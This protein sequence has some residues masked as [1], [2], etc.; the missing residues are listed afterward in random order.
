MTAS[1][2]LASW[3]WPELALLA[4]MVLVCAGA[5][6]W[7][8]RRAVVSPLQR[9]EEQVVRLARG[10][11]QRPVWL[12]G[13]LVGELVPLA[14][15]LEQT[16]R[17]LVSKLRSTTELNLQLESEVARRSAELSRRNTELA[18][19]LSRLQAARDELLRAEKLA[20]VGRVAAQVTADIVTPVEAL[21]RLV[22]PLAGEVAALREI[23]Q[24]QPGRTAP[25][26]PPDTDRARARVA[27]LRQALVAIEEAAL[28]T[29][30]LVRA[31]RAYARPGGSVPP[32]SAPGLPAV[33]T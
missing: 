21:S 12:D 27:I 31:M 18:E 10:E 33:P 24:P 26:T 6:V 2:P 30:D 32:P 7:L 29:R 28:R 16:R 8:V 14:L 1:H 19:T 5:I 11:L 17:A 23:V 4:A 9:L 3:R 25:P 22:A 13:S 15:D 20:A